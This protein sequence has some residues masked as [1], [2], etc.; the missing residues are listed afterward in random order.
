MDPRKL[1]RKALASPNNLRFGEMTALTE[2]F[3][4]KLSRTSGSHHIYSRAGIPELV[5]SAQ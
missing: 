5:G 2:A 1:L 4:F 3:G